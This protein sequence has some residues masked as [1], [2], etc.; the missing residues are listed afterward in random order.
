MTGSSATATGTTVEATVEPGEPAPEYS[1]GDGSVWCSW[2]APS[3]GVVT[4]D[5]AGSGFY[6]ALGVYTGDALSGLEVVAEGNGWDTTAASRAT[7]HATA[8]TTYRL[9]ARA[10]YTSAGGTL[11]LD[12]ALR[13]PPANDAFVRTRPRTGMAARSGSGSGSRPA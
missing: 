12:L 6:V 5:A 2:T 9:L 13:L 4:L 11:T 3:S 1:N 8:E 10:R 7:F